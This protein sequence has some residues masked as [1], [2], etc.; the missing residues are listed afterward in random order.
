MGETVR[1]ASVGQP[2]TLVVRVDDDGLPAARYR[3]AARPPG[4]G[5]A[6]L[7]RAQLTPPTRFTVQKANGLHVA[8][9]V[10]RGEAEVIFDPPQIKTWEDTRAGANSPWS[11]L[12]AVPAPPT[13]GEWTVRVTFDRPG[14]YVLRGRAD[15]GG[16][17]DDTEVTIIVTPLA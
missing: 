5:P 11:P 14:T 3:P 16:L 10:L 8:W 13:H 12:F 2:V 15:D 6:T 17:Y 4:D 1:T 9:F 7:S